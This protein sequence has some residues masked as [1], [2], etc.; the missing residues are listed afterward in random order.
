MPNEFDGGRYGCITKS[1]SL[2]CPALMTSCDPIQTDNILLTNCKAHLKRGITSQKLLTEW[3][4][5]KRGHR[6][7]RHRLDLLLS[8]NAAHQQRRHDHKDMRTLHSDDIWCKTS[9]WV[10][11]G[12]GGSSLSVQIS[13]VGRVGW[14]CRAVA[15]GV[16]R[17]G[18]LARFT[19]CAATLAGL[20]TACRVYRL[21]RLVAV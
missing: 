15:S 21:R 14:R 4:R 17:N 2:W 19:L 12:G 5:L 7:L 16:E 18:K 3:R 6:Q 20:T 11:W 13:G 8:R 1:Y 10:V 9:G